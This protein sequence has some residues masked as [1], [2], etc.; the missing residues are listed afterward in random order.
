VS[1]YNQFGARYDKLLK[2]YPDTPSKDFGSEQAIEEAIARNARQVASALTPNVYKQMTEPELELVVR[3]ATAGQTTAQLGLKPIVAG[4]LRMWIVYQGAIIDPRII[5]RP[6]PGIGECSFSVNVTTGAVTAISPALQ[7]DDQVYAS[8]QVD[9]EHSSFALPSLAE[10]AVYGTAAELGTQ[11]YSQ[12]QDEWALVKQY[13]DTWVAGI[14]ALREGTFIPD[15][16]R[17]M[18]WYVEVERSSGQIGSFSLPR[19]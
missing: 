14:A 9:T 8:Y 17:A 3:R 11:I 6:I 13:N 19:G 2:L 5:P 15:E 1:T 18:R 7:A 12:A 16:L 4:S 10:L